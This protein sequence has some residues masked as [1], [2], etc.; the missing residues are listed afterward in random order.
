MKNA[1]TPC[2]RITNSA[3]RGNRIA[4]SAELEAE[5]HPDSSGI[6]S[7]LRQQLAENPPREATAEDFR[8]LKALV[9]EHI[10]SFSERLQ[11]LRPVEYE[12][13]LLVRAHFSPSEIS[14]L[15]GRTRDYI[16]ITRKRILKKLTGS[17]GLAKELDARIMS[18]S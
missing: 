11:S 1:D 5:Q 9:N 8:Q 6:V 18:I 10:P 16:T 15:T 14:K 3:E 7:K 2:S 17:E 12:I 13:C 4:N